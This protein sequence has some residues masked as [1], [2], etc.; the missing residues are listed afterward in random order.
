M[1]FLRYIGVLIA[2]SA[3][4]LGQALPAGTVLPISLK[5]RIESKKESAGKKFEG[6]VMQDVQSVDGRLIKRGA[7]VSGQIV[8]ATGTKLVLRFDGLEDSGKTIPLNVRLLAVASMMSIADAQA[9]VNA[10]PDIPTNEWTTR[11]VGGDVVFRGRGIAKSG[12]GVTGTWVQ[13]GSVLMMLTP[14]PDMGCESGPGY[15]RA[16]SLWVFS[17][18]ACGAY[19]LKDVVIARDAEA[20]PGNIEL[21][22]EGNVDIRPGSGWLLIENAAPGEKLPPKAGK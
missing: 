12:S 5:S 15:E 4:S 18:S 10:V 19:G 22:S 16:Q 14:N 9:P 1:N 2:F 17:S 11:Q 6:S 8:S 3:I 13:G 7:R 21:D 20:T